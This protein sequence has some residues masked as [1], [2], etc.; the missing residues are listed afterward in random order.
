MPDV[1]RE[2]FREWMSLLDNLE[3]FD[4][5]DPWMATP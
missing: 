3:W 4:L 2:R 5:T 1:L